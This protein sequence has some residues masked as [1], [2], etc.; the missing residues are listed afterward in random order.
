MPGELFVEY[1]LAAQ[2]M[3]PDDF[4]AMAAYGDYGTG[5]I[6]TEIAYSQGGYETGIVSRVAPPVEKVLMDAIKKLLSNQP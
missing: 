1:Q 6:G 3:R 2:Q 5:Y 4:I